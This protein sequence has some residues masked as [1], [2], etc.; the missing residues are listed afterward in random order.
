MNKTIWA[1]QGSF[2]GWWLN[3]GPSGIVRIF[4]G[5][6]YGWRLENTRPRPERGQHLPPGRHLR[7]QQRPPLRQRCPRH[8][9][10]RP[11]RWL[12]RRRERDALR[13]LLDRPRPVLAWHPRRGKLLPRRPDAQ[14]QML[15]HYNAVISG[16]QATSAANRLVTT[17]PHRSGEHVGAGG[18]GCG[19]AG[20]NIDVRRRGTGRGQARSPTAT[21]GSVAARAV[22]DIAG[23]SRQQLH[24]V[25]ADV[26]AS[27]RAAVTGQQ[28]RRLQP[29]NLH[30]NRHRQQQRNRAREHDAADDHR[31][32]PAGANTGGEDGEVDRGPR[33]SPTPTSG[34]AATRRVPAASISPARTGG[35]I[36]SW[37]PMSVRAC[38][39]G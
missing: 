12:Q 21:A 32:A 34:G 2:N 24:V 6:G 18:V 15:A 11:R 19:A 5:D 27:L 4:V 9:P 16:S 36:W 25:A 30:P 10:A 14:P 23:A 35:A 29:G 26:G 8:A 22:A 1:T 3:T 17:Q 37:A 31:G 28:Q 38:G 20:A 33:R 13:R 7:R 39:C